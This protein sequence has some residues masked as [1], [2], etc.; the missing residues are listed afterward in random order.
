MPVVEAGLDTRLGDPVQPIRKNAM[1]III[2]LKLDRN[3][4]LW[5]KKKKIKKLEKIWIFRVFRSTLYATA[6]SL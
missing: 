4:C 3:D 1:K 6:V 2:I 5:L